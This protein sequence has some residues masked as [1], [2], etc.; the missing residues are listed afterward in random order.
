MKNR[1]IIVLL[2][3]SSLTGLAQ[4]K[5]TPINSYESPLFR[6]IDG[7]YFDLEHDNSTLS[8][9]SYFNILD[10]LQGR[11]AGLQVYTIRGIRIP[12]IRNYPATVYVD[13]IRTDASILN[14]LP[15]ADMA[16]IKIIKSPNAAIASGPGGAIIVYTKRGEEGEEEEDGDDR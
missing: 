3:I 16:L 11:V 9:N 4:V 10:W 6:N 15:V 8:A 7:T 14:M 5:Q 13:E 12:V 2:L 1:L